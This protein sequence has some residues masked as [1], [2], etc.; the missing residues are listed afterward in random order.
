M[1]GMM[2][3]SAVTLVVKTPNRS[4]EDLQISCALNWTVEKLKR[5]L[6]SVYPSKPESKKQRLIY[7][8]QLLLDH[9]IVK[10]FLRE[11]QD[12]KLHTVHLVCPPPSSESLSSP[13][14]SSLSSSSS[15]G[16]SS[17]SPTSTSV[18]STPSSPTQTMPQ[19]VTDGLRYRRQNTPPMPM[20]MPSPP[21]MWPMNG[22]A[23]FQAPMFA[24]PQSPQMNHQLW[25]QHMQQMYQQHQMAA[26]RQPQANF[27]YMPPNMQMPFWPYQRPP[28]T[29]PVTPPVNI[30]P[31]V[32]QQPT[33]PQIPQAPPQ[34]PPQADARNI[35]QRQPAQPRNQEV[36]MNAQGGIAD[37]DDDEENLNNDWLDKIYTLCRV[38]ILLSIV[39]F[40]SS[41][42]RFL[43]L[44][45]SV[46]LI[47]MYQWGAFQWLFQN[48]NAQPQ[49][50]ALF[51][52]LI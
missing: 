13:S 21:P 48:R 22:Q 43:M 28:G 24:P 44:I 34:P 15:T 50:R 47:Y 2:E 7:S 27:M 17:A 10:E 51:S 33:P 25:M 49:G 39:W 37:D 45:L 19:P 30:T 4:I 16:L 6:S 40:Y 5:H 11:H 41:T 31:M 8:G 3:S 52:F 42:G 14:S 38:A 32:A 1:E 46:V 9:Q 36:R 18:A 23:P 26:A 35:P 29:H 12:G 20:F